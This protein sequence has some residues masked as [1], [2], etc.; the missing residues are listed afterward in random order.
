MY[1]RASATLRRAPDGAASTAGEG[2]ATAGVGL[3]A[4]PAGVDVDVDVEVD[5]D[6]VLASGFGA[7]PHAIDKSATPP[8]RAAI[9]MCGV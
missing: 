3:V 1:L 5:V 2:S 8:K 6:D 4:S 9:R 7:D